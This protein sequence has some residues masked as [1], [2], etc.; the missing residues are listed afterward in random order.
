[1]AGRVAG[2]SRARP[3]AYSLVFSARLVPIPGFVFVWVGLF[4]FPPT[5]LL[6]IASHDFANRQDDDETPF[7]Q[8]HAIETTDHHGP[9]I[10]KKA[11]GYERCAFRRFAQYAFIRFDTAAF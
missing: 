11:V 2:R 1:L 3:R 8:F 4:T 5:G 10:L 7:E 6:S 9:L